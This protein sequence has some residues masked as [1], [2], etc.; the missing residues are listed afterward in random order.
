M[1]CHCAAKIQHSRKSLPQLQ[2]VPVK[3]EDIRKHLLNWVIWEA[4]LRRMV[5][6]PETH[7]SSCCSEVWLMFACPSSMFIAV[8]EYMPGGAIIHHDTLLCRPHP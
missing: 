6:H 1:C 2:I 4:L 8:I 5:N 3:L 7:A